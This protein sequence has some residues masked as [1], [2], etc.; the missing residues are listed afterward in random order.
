VIT[1][2]VAWETAQANLIGLG[3]ARAQYAHAIAV[4][5]GKNPEDLDI[6]HSNTVPTLPT[7]PVGVPS[8]LLQRRPDISPRNVPWL[9]RMPPLALPWRRTTPRYR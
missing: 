4:L 8:T 7:V 5:V 9:R 6:P 3:V 2:R 1:A